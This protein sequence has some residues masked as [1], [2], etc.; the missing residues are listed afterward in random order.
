MKQ[1]SSKEGYPIYLSAAYLRIEIKK[2][3]NIQPPTFVEKLKK[4]ETHSNNFETIYFYL[5]LIENRKNSHYFLTY[6]FF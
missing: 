1:I 6:M 4:D 5:N 3:L 2:I